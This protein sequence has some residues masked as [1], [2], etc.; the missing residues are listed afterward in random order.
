M[1]R[2]CKGDIAK[3]HLETAVNI[4]LRGLDRPSVITLAGAAN[5]ILDTL[6]KRAGKEPFLD[7][8]RRVHHESVGHMPKRKS[9]AHHIDKALGIIAHKHLS[10][11]D[12]DPLEL[13]LDALAFRALSRAIV[14]YIALNGPDEP[15]VRAFPSW[16]WTSQWPGDDGTIQ[17]H[18][19]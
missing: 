19:R 5:G 13:D 4:F 12:A 9:Y 18:S 17:A 14:D 6:V 7:Y 2:Y 11:D 3:C 10:K 16:A 8:A 1:T 15:F